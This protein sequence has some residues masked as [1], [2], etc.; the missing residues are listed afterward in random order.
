VAQRFEQSVLVPGLARLPISLASKQ[1][2]LSDGPDI[3][4]GKII[5]IN[6]GATVIAAL[7]AR[8]R[9]VTEALSYWD[10]HAQLDSVGLYSLII[11]G[12]TPEGGAIQINDPATVKVPFVGQLLPPFDT[13]TTDTH[14]GV[15]PICT[16]LTGGPCPFHAMTLT[17]ALAAGKPVAYLIGT[18]AHCQF[19]TCAPGLEA[20]IAVSERLGD[21]LSIVHAE[22]YVDDSATVSTPA[23]DAYHL[24]YEPVV[25]LTD[26]NGAIV[27]RLDAIW[28]Q[29]ELDEAVDALFT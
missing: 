27:S 15:N 25:W 3:L 22:V 9:I 18:P 7:S 12:G 5:D 14:R 29:S 13:P 24:T 28:D 21:K 17:E 4:N 6:T 2:L 26:A 19:G 16:R 11:D 20:L 8:R 1:A 10:F 23:V